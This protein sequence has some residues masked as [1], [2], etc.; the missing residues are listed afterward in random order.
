MRYSAFGMMSF[1]RRQESKEIDRKG[2]LDILDPC[3]R[4]DDIKGNRDDIRGGQ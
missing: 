2:V 1:L 3:L 4:R